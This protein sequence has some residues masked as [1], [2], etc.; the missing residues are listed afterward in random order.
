[1]GRRQCRARRRS[2]REGA[3]RGGLFGRGKEPPR[4]VPPAT[5]AAATPAD[6]DARVRLVRTTAC[7]WWCDRPRRGRG[8][9]DEDAGQG[10]QAAA[11][12]S[13]GA[14]RRDGPCQRRHRP[15]NDLRR[16]RAVAV[17]QGP[18]ALWEAL[19]SSGRR[20]VG[21]LQAPPQVAFQVADED[22]S[23]TTAS[24]AAA[25]T[26]SSAAAATTTATSA[27]AAVFEG[28]WDVVF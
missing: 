11:A 15:G 18:L 22:S 27:A 13:R 28:F 14:S 16:G 20:R 1:M 17:R 2:R 25:A 12:D 10:G 26:S 4:D 19:A 24:T 8:L 23:P 5:S 21:A 3:L 9:P 7:W 6:G